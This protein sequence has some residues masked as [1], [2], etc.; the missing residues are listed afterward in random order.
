MDN[1]QMIDPHSRHDAPTAALF[2]GH[3]RQESNLFPK[4]KCLFLCCGSNAFLL[5]Q[6]FIVLSFPFIKWSCSTFEL[7]PCFTKFSSNFIRIKFVLALTTY[8][9]PCWSALTL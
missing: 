3:F 4:G 7:F 9:F 2:L 6:Y 1:K 5:F 8:T